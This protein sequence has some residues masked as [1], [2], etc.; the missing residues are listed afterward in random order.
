MSNDPQNKSL[1][2]DKTEDEVLREIVETDE[3]LGEANRKRL[4]AELARTSEQLRAALTKLQSRVTELA[5]TQAK[6]SEITRRQAEGAQSRKVPGSWPS[7]EIYEAEI[8]TLDDHYVDER[9]D[10]ASTYITLFGN[11]QGSFSGLKRHL[12]SVPALEADLND[13]LYDI[14]SKLTRLEDAETCFLAD[15]ERLTVLVSTISAAPG[16]V[17][18]TVSNSSS[19]VVEELD[20][21]M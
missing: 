19:I 15:C 18:Q 21:E 20:E 8:V 7:H 16:P 5:E 9:K 11:I 2:G 10:W 14:T 13:I 1:I 17:E 6:I 3:E 12:K 4:E